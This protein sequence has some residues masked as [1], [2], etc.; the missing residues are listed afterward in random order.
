MQLQCKHCFHDQCIRG[1]TIVGKKVRPPCRTRR[2]HSLSMQVTSVLLL[3]SWHT[4]LCKTMP[5]ANASLLKHCESLS[6]VGGALCVGH[7]P[8]VPGEGGPEENLCRAALGDPQLDLV[9]ILPV[10]AVILL[11]LSCHAES[12]TIS[13]HFQR[14]GEATDALRPGPADGIWH[15]SS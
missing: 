8:C 10:C 6:N 12:M 5:T 3:R 13:L 7:V 9:A 14:P 1:W 4:V 2:L 11:H 15:C